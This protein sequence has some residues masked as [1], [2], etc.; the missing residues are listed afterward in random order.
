MTDN[1]I[2]L[3]NGAAAIDTDAAE[4]ERLTQ[5]FRSKFSAV[6]DDLVKRTKLSVQQR[7]QEEE[8]KKK[9]TRVKTIRVAVA[10]AII[11]GILIATPAREYAVT[12][13]EKT[14]A[15][16]QEWIDRIFGSDDDLPDGAKHELNISIPEIL[17]PDVNP[18]LN[19]DDFKKPKKGKVSPSDY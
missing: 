6:P 13:A 9:A 19:E 15:V 11:S 17:T 16:I 1:Q 5:S 10:A 14:L 7:I 12:A 2:K 18:G 8:L 3:V 4:L